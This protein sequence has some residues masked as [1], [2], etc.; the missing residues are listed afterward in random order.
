MEEIKTEKGYLK[1][2]IWN[3]ENLEI[4][5]IF[6]MPNFR[7]QGEGR[8]MV[9][10]VEK[11]AKERKLACIYCFTRENNK[12]A[13]EFYGAMEFEKVCDIQDFYRSENGI[14]YIKKL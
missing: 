6:V 3:D 1:Y 4:V 7:K 10:E 5:G 2:K 13:Q 8:K 14:M 12:E 11:I 9:Q